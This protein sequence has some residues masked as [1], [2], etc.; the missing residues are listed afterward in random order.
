[1]IRKAAKYCA[2]RVSITVQPA[3]TT[4]MVMKLLSRMKISEMPSTPRW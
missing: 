2:T 1:M 4:R 3:I